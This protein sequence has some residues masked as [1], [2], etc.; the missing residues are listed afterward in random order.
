MAKDIFDTILDKEYHQL[1]STELAEITEFC[2][3]EQEFLA[4]KQVLAHSKT[5]AEGPKLSPKEETKEKLDNL[6]AST[7]SGIRKIIP[8]YLNP[9]VQI[10]AVLF[11]GFAVWMFFSKSGNLETVQMAENKIPEKEK[12]DQKI[13]TNQSDETNNSINEISN[14]EKEN[15]IEVNTTESSY[16][17]NSEVANSHTTQ[18]SADVVERNVAKTKNIETSLNFDESENTVM[19]YPEEATSKKL[20][21]VSTP[22]SSVKDIPVE[23]SKSPYKYQTV[24]SMNVSE[25]KN[26]MNYLVARY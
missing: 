26:V 3:N 12:V 11:I 22:V 7:Y 19:T 15:V 16:S 18:H 25:Q 10:A 8:F 21:K 14:N 23:A 9:I 1:T 17:Y 20:S 6:F 13:K 5:I 2:K 24:T 4:M